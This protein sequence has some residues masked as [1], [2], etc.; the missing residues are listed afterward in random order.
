ME[1]IL[2]D[3]SGFCFGVKNAVSSALNIQNPGSRIFTY[4]PLIHNKAVIEELEHKGIRQL[5]TIEDLAEGDTVIIRSHGVSKQVMDLLSGKNVKIVDATCPYVVNI[6]KIVEKYYKEGYRIII[7]GD[8][9]HPEVQ[10]INGWCDNS[11]VIIHSVEQ[12]QNSDGY[13]KCCVVAQTTANISKWKDIVCSLLGKSR[14]L[15]IFNT[16]C[17]ATEQRQNAAEDLAKRCDAVLVL[18]GFNS[19][20]TKKL[21]EI[22]SQYCPK[23]FHVE[24]IDQ[25]CIDDL[26][27][28]DTLGITAGASTPDWIIKE[29]IDKMDNLKNTNE[30]NNEQQ[31][32]MSEYEKTFIRLHAGDVVRGRIIYTTDDEATVDIGYKADGIITREEL[33]F[34]GNISPKELLKPGDEIDVYIVK[35]NDGEGNVLLSKKKVD[36]EKSW[37]FIEDSFNNKETVDARITQIVKGGVIAEVKG[38]NVFIPA[39]QADVKYMED[40]SELMGKSVRI[41]ITAYDP[42]KNRVVGSRKVVLAEEIKAKKKQLLDTIQPGEIL[43]G[44]VRR[45]TDF[46]VFVDLGGID[47][48]I[49]ISEL[50]WNRVKHPSDIVKEGNKVE[51]YVVSVDKDKERVSL[52]LKKTLPEPWDNIENRI[53]TGD[54][55]E[56]KVVRIAPFGAFVEVEK[57]VDGLVH[58]SQISNERVNK[59]EDVL[60]VGEAV[61]AKVMEVNTADKKLSL[62]IKEATEEGKKEDTEEYVKEE[63]QDPVTIGDIITNKDQE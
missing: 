24:T 19:S 1:I 35:V 39:S 51:V 18:G 9:D 42:S 6:H 20:N 50:S 3:Y 43:P 29:A 30:E 54:I 45:I 59:I 37:E 22:C 38:I 63:E 33:S 23:T 61:K 60:K 47:G 57:G 15:T 8:S 36:A 13:S 27:G 14:E 7:I 5:D 55:I 17:T 58:I 44:I 32:M 12:A 2:A 53:K 34:E 28:V 25:L 26:E 21:K 48:L 4:G 16:I 10:G 40:L 49:H 62:S 31:S 41:V 11:A 46:G 56:G 52:S